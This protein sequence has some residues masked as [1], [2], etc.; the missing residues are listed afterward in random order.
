M[1]SSLTVLVLVSIVTLLSAGVLAPFLHRRQSS[2]V[3]VVFAVSAA[4]CLLGLAAGMAAVAGGGVEKLVLPIGLPDLPFHLRLDPL[5]GFFIT[6]ISL[7]S[8]CISIYSIGYVKGFIGQKTVTHLA[9]FYPF[10]IAGMLLVLISDDAFFFLISWEIMAASSYFL[11]MYDDAKPEN[12][13]AAFLY[14]LIAHVGALAILLSFGVMAGSAAGFETFKGYTFDA[15]RGASPAPFWAGVA[16][17]LGFLGFAAK[18][19]VVPLHVW[20]PEAHPAAPS[21]VSAL[22]SGAMLKT[23]VYGIIRLT[24]DILHVSQLWW[25]ELVLIAGLVSAIMGILYALMENDL[26]RLLAY[27]SVENIGIILVGLGLSM[28]F[29]SFNQPVLA[30]LAATAAL[31]HVLNHAVFKGLLFMGAGAVLH[32]TGERNMEKMGGLIHRL[33]WTAPLF[34]VGAVS[35]S[36][37][38]PFNGFVSEW[39]TF[40]AFLMSPA[41][42]NPRLTLIIPMGAALLALTAALAASCFVKAFGVAFLG[43]SRS[44]Q[45]Q[46]AHEAPW[47]MRIAM[48]I[49]AVICLLLGVFPTF[50]IGW[51]DTVTSQLSGLASPNPASARGWMWLTP[52]AAERASYA[53]PM[54]FLGIISTVVIVFLLL[55]ARKNAIHRVPLWDCGFKKVTPSMQYTSTSFSMPPRIIFGFFFRIKES[56][57][58]DTS[59]GRAAQFPAKLRYGLKVRDRIWGWL[60]EPVADY[61]FR[62]ATFSAKLQ[63]GRIHIYLSYSFFTI[64][65]LLL[66]TL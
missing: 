13:R 28:I 29:M 25:G 39:M 2:L 5:S 66:F 58:P 42:P 37:L 45:C 20:L 53:A 3:W 55:H 41:L 24:F 57:K 6:V 15:M 46:T 8:F 47:S 23:A 16:F 60:Y 48:L 22:M 26:K 30:A 59:G 34:L 35:I 43:H 54:V 52:V 1:E 65:F 56:L 14:I 49:S 51:M 31:Y 11:V 17:L 40:Q 27:S 10:F 62:L 9:L 33:P 36:A 19:G 50:V 64:L 63:H 38:P 4:A 12:R 7:L 21:N 44:A 61:A 32:A 18:A